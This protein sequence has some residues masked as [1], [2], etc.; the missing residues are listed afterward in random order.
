MFNIED[1]LNTTIKPIPQDI[2]KDLYTI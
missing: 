2:D 1:D